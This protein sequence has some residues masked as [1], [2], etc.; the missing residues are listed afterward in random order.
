M[1][2]LDG[3]GVMGNRFYDCELESMKVK[4]KECEL[5]TQCKIHSDFS[6][7]HL[8]WDVLFYKIKVSL[9]NICSY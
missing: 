3:E 9:V 7:V 1:S 8:F 6:M 4:L 2:S 5:W